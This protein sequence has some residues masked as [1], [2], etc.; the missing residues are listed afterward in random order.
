[1]TADDVQQ[2]LFAVLGQYNVLFD[3]QKIGDSTIY[4]VSKFGVKVIYLDGQM[5]DK[6]ILNG[7]HDVWIHPDYDVKKSRKKIVWALVQGGYFHYLRHNYKNT[8]SK[9]LAF[10]GWDRALIDERL[11]RYKDLPKYNYLR[12]MNKDGRLESSTYILSIDPGFYDFIVE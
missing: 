5:F 11:R 4:E 10:E 8:F 9:T 12:E 6:K 1:M 7:W 3:T 2:I